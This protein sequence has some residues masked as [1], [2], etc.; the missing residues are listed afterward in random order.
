M[1]RRDGAHRA[2]TRSSVLVAALLVLPGCASVAGPDAGAAGTAAERFHAAVAAGDGLAACSLLAPTT[3]RERA[4]AEEAPCPEAVLA[5]DLPAAA[6]SLEGHAYG[7]QA[8][9]VLDGDTVFL[10]GSG[11]DWLVVA[12]GCTPRPERPYDCTIAGG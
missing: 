3:A 10:T 12:A 7:R 2:V 5:V 1:T 11:A 4:G 6:T 8:Q 9:V